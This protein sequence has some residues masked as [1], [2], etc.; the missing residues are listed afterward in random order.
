MFVSALRTAAFSQLRWRFVTVQSIK[1]QTI[2]RLRPVLVLALGLLFSAVAMSRAQAQSFFGDLGDGVTV[3][4][5]QGST[6][7]LPKVSKTTRFLTFDSYGSSQIGPDIASFSIAKPGFLVMGDQFDLVT[8]MAG[9][10]GH[11]PIEVLAFG[12]GYQMPLNDSGI[13]WFIQGDHAEVVLGGAENRALDVRGDR[14]NLSFGFRKIWTPAADVTT[15]ATLEF[16]SRRST[17]QVLGFPALAEDLRIVQVSLRH[18]RGVPF[19]FR[20]RYGA[21][22]AKG[23]AGFGASGR[24]NP[25]ASLPG[26]SAQFLRVSVAAELSLPVSA[27]LVV[28]AGIAGQWAD[29]ALPL[30][31]RCGYGTN[32]FSRGFDQTVANGD[33]CIAT[34]VELARYLTLPTQ[35]PPSGLLTQGFAGVDGGRVWNHGSAALA[36]TTRDWS[37]LSVGLR[38]LRGGN[39]AEIAVTRILNDF[40]PAVRQDESRLW[41]RVG[42]RF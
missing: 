36:S 9:F 15:R 6:A 3:G 13:A 42:T 10:L 17:G 30:S 23:L 24:I 29:R 28:N 11:G 8:V 31:E 37:S 38:A 16:Q 18:E 19:G 14:T 20:T 41:V 33:R 35:K 26:A 4:V 12:L 5:D 1:P 39:I 2:A 34:R 27:K 21:S 7:L 32:A 22:V 40:N 25:A